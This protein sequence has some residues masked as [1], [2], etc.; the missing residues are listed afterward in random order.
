MDRVLLVIPARLGSTRLP[1]KPLAIIAGKTMIERVWRNAKASTIPSRVIVATDSDEIDKQVKSFG[2]ECCI[3]SSNCRTGTDRVAEVAEQF[4]EYQIVFNLQGD[5]PLTPP[6]IIDQVLSV[7]I[8]DQKIG[9][10]T[11]VMKLSGKT[12]RDFLGNKARGSA[13]GTTVVFDK[14]GDALYF[15]KGVIPFNRSGTELDALLYQ[16]IGLYAY[17]REILFQLQA[18]PSGRFEEVEK[19]EQLRALE[20]G[21]PIRCVEV[22][23]RGKTLASVDAPED[24]AVVESIIKKEGEL[25][26]SS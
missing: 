8:A 4:P 24:I 11:P 18:L 26:I 16:H 13:T 15:S 7:M 23:C 17:R 21:I 20:N 2:A 6:W 1:R 12:L 5:S 19:L 25:V 10:T 9:L 22:D 3:T 14:E